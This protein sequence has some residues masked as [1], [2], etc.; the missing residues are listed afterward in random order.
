MRLQAPAV[1]ELIADHN[2]TDYETI[3]T[4]MR[5]LS[6]TAEKGGL[7]LIAVFAILSLLIVVNSV[8]MAIV[9]RAEELKVMRLVGAS[10]M[11]IRG[12]LLLEGVLASF[13]AVLIAS[14][15]FVAILYFADPYLS[16]YLGEAVPLNTYFLVHWWV[17][18]L[19][20]WVAFSLLTVLVSLLAIRRYLKV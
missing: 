1:S 9:G 13:F 12:P 2:F 15:L 20:E 11:T 3:I 18:I 19:V 6:S 8:R 10:N 14:A 5:S 16:T 4:R 17:I 7:G